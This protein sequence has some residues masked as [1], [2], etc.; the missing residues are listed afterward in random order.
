MTERHI[1]TPQEKR[2]ALAARV[3]SQFVQLKALNGSIRK[4][5]TQE[6]EHAR[7]Q[8]QEGQSHDNATSPTF[9][10]TELAHVS[11]HI[12]FALDQLDALASLLRDGSVDE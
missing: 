9:I 11:T 3:T 10:S 1:S 6:S 8:W 2:D 4:L 12:D 5:R 7:R